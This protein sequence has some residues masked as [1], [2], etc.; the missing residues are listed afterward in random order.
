LRSVSGLRLSAREKRTIGLGIGV[1][2]IAVLLVLAVL[3]FGRHWQAREDLISAEI[4]RLARLRGLVAA[5]ATLE[6]AVSMR[7]NAM[8]TGPRLLDDRTAALAASSLQSMLQDV[9]TQSRVVISRLDVAGAPETDGA[10]LPTIPATVSAIGDIYGITEMLTLIQHA[11][12]LLEV[13]ELTVRPNPALKGELL[14]MTVRLRA[15]WTGV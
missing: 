10:L 9:A 3:P 1:S 12:R 8:E 15:G 2:A 7:A 4:D 14:Q 13:L 5:E 6:Q 11:P